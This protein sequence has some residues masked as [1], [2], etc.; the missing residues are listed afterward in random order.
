MALLMEAVTAIRN[1]RGEM[2]I[3]PAP[4]LTATVKAA[5]GDGAAP[6]RARAR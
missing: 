5:P 1:I 3:S 6:A 4:A 2:R